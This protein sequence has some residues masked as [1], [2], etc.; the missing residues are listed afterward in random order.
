LDLNTTAKMLEDVSIPGVLIAIPFPP[1]TEAKESNKSPTFLLYAPP[2]A[3][4]RKPLVDSNDDHTKRSLVKRVERIW[5]K[6]IAQGYDI[7]AGKIPD[8]GTWKRTKGAVA[9]VGLA[10]MART[11][12]ADQVIDRVESASISSYL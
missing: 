12:R 7:K 6:E 8:A 3:V 9:R 10:L 1:A 4:Y 11:S 2:R 5:Q